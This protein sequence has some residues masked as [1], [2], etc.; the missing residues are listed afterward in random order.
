MHF[1][2]TFLGHAVLTDVVAAYLYSVTDTL[3]QPNTVAYMHQPFPK[4]QLLFL[5]IKLYERVCTRSGQDGC[6]SQMSKT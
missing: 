6:H 5:G 3:P 2:S 4:D 1:F